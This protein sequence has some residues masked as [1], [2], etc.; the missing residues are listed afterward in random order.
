MPTSH[1]SLESIQA[2]LA[3][4]RFA[5]VGLSRHAKDFSAMLFQEFVRRGYDVLPVN[6]NAKE[7]LGHACFARV[8]DIQ[9]PVE[10]ALLMTS[11]QVTEAVVP[12][13][14][15]AGIRQ[16]WMYGIGGKGAVSAKALAFCQERGI[17]V[18]PGECPFMFFPNN[19]FHLLHGLWNKLTGQYPQR[20]A[21]SHAA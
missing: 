12:D 11:P 10:A 8:Q 9:P 5:M 19:G 17:E 4:N 14:A 13:C 3:Q 6:P 16:I 21:D 15:A 20:K 7:I 18:I 1:A 2:F